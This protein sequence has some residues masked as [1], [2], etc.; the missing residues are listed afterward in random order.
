MLHKWWLM[1]L[2]QMEDLA[3]THLCTVTNHYQRDSLRV[4]VLQHIRGLRALY[5]GAS[6]AKQEYPLW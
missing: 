4:R 3:W 1:R 2:I 5:D 6:G